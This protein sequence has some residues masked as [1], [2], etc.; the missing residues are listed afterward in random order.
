MKSILLKSQILF[1]AKYLR[2][3]TAPYFNFFISFSFFKSESML[4]KLYT[5]NVFYACR[6]INKSSKLNVTYTAMHGVGEKYEIE[7]F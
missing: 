1:I 4:C 7:A 5:R 6:E 3:E 2:I